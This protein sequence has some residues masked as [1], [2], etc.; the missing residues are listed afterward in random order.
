MTMYRKTGECFF[1]FLFF[2]SLFFLYPPYPL[3]GA[4]QPVNQLYWATENYP[5][6]YKLWDESLP[7]EGGY[8]ALDYA[9]RQNPGSGTYANTVQIENSWG[10]LP[11]EKAGYCKVWRDNLPGTYYGALYYAYLYCNG[12]KRDMMDNTSC[13]SQVPELDRNANLGGGCPIPGE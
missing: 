1:F 2:F 3:H 6:E 8:E 5:T 7:Y 4:E 12:V 9:C 11:A 10:D 13:Q